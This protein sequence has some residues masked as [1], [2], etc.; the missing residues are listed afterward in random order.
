[1]T[2]NSGLQGDAPQAARARTR[3]LGSSTVGR[4]D[5]RAEPMKSGKIAENSSVVGA[6][7]NGG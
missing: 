4:P 6:Y 3:T 1:M 2:P 5:A 7:S